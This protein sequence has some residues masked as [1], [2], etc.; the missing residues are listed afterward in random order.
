MPNFLFFSK[1][2]RIELP[3]SEKF[4]GDGRW[5]TS[6]RVAKNS[7]GTGVGKLVVGTE[8]MTGAWIP[9][10]TLLETGVEKRVVAHRNII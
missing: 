9:I 7:L 6:C 8:K 4:S 5:E 1:A 3:G 10:G 2:L